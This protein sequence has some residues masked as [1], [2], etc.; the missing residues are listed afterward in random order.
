MI[1]KQYGRAVAAHET[2]LR[3]ARVHS[4][5]GGPMHLAP[6]HTK[7]SEPRR[8]SRILLSWYFISLLSCCPCP[9]T[10]LVWCALE[11]PIVFERIVTWCVLML[12]LVHLHMSML[13][14]LIIPML[15]QCHLRMSMLVHV[16]L[17]MHMFM[18]VRVHL[19][20]SMQTNNRKQK[21]G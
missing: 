17:H 10:T 11:K 8:E 19:H 9:L 1:A 6:H 21:Q 14:H 13:A 4:K 12:L 5:A 16:H 20:M 15:E 18:L 3:H 2:A 7:T